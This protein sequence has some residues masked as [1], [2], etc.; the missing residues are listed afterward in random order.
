M[1]EG[2]RP[3]SIR[4]A[5]NTPGHTRRSRS[6]RISGSWWTVSSSAPAMRS[7]FPTRMRSPFPTSMCPRCPP[8]GGPAADGPAGSG[9]SRS[10]RRPG[11]PQRH[12]RPPLREHAEASGTDIAA[13]EIQATL[14]GPER[15]ARDGQLRNGPVP[16][17]LHLHELAKATHQ[18]QRRLEPHQPAPSTMTSSLR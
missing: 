16:V 10:R 13:I 8:P 4:T 17:K 2:G 12:P 6:S 11:C 9:H 3:G 14:A 1:P 7:P 15:Y 18:R 5:R